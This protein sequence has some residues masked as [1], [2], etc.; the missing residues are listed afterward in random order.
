MPAAIITLVILAF[1]ALTAKGRSITK[2]PLAAIPLMTLRSEMLSGQH[3]HQM[4]LLMQSKPLSKPLW[5][6]AVKVSVS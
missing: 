3:F 6:F 5:N 1:S 4:T 2:L